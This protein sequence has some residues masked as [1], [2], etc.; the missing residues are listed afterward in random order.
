M[1]EDN[2]IVILGIVMMVLGMIV[3][4]GIFNR[5][6]PVETPLGMRRLSYALFAV[7]FVTIISQSTP[8]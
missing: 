5:I 8:T 1:S 3:F 4:F 2:P 7:G 6:G